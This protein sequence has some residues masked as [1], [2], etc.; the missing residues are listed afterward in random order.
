MSSLVGGF[1]GRS[2]GI[3]GLIFLMFG[4]ILAGGVR[5]VGVGGRGP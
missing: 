5:F 3:E 2:L 1:G 4:L